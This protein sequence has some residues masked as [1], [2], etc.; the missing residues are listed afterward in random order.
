MQSTRSALR[1]RFALSTVLSC[2]AISACD[3][4]SDPTTPSSD[5]DPVP[6]SLQVTPTT[7][8]LFVPGSYPITATVLDQ[9][10]RTVTGASVSFSTRDSTTAAVDQEGVVTA[11]AGGNTWVVVEAAP[12]SDSI[13]VTVR[14][15]T[16]ENEARGRVLGPEG[17]VMRWASEGN[18]YEY[19]GKENQ[20]RTV[21]FMVNE[22]WADTVAV[23]VLPAQVPSSSMDL[24]RLPLDTYL[25]GED[26][27]DLP[28]G[29]AYFFMDDDE[30]ESSLLYLSEEGSTLEVDAVEHTKGAVTRLS[31]HL[32]LQASGYE[33]T[34]E[35]WGAPPNAT[36]TGDTLTLYM[37][38]DSEADP[39]VVGQATI[40]LR[41]GPIPMENDRQEAYYV[42][43]SEEDPDYGGVEIEGPPYGEIFMPRPQVGSYVM[44]LEHK[45][46]SG[47]RWVV[48]TDPR[49]AISGEGSLVIDH[50]E[51]AADG[52]PST[53]S[54]HL[55]TIMTYNGDHWSDP[56]VTG[57]FIMDFHIPILT[58]DDYMGYLWEAPEQ[59]KEAPLVARFLP[60]DPRRTR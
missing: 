56:K 7:L 24:E 26:F 14:Y 59:V 28:A 53:A 52:R 8:T 48:F 35:S 30:R 12:Y 54:G 47:Y 29:S 4:G 37:D 44:D 60:R 57:T 16:V 5:V 10:G 6:S 34:W 15:Q 17:F 25:Q 19:L 51:P 3:S 36:P 18:A 2:L 46:E 27:S 11:I 55:E 31:G 22:G 9:N 23:L 49:Y 38:F 42:S 20:D 32:T 33:L 41:G 21:L 58:Y 43:W 39:W 13:P 45:S 50:V 40:T 1:S